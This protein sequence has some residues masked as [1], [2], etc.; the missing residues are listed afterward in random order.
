MP[1][2][3][4][5]LF[6]GRRHLPSRGRL[7]FFT[8]RLSSVNCRQPTGK[9]LDTRPLKKASAITCLL[10]LMHLRFP[11]CIC[12]HLKSSACICLH[13]QSSACIPFILSLHKPN[14]YDKSGKNGGAIPA[15]SL[16]RMRRAEQLSQP[17]G[18]NG[19]YPSFKNEVWWTNS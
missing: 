17:Y 16:L 7:L 4:R 12:L 2:C 13:L 18:T 10:Y 15:G 1:L 9:Q 5:K 14:I 8:V 3:D 6:L 11:A 19:G